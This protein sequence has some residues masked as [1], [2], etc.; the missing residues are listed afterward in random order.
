M[1]RNINWK[2]MIDPVPHPT[3][4]VPT[5]H[6]L[7]DANVVGEYKRGSTILIESFNKAIDTSR[8]S[9]L[10]EAS[11]AS[12]PIACTAISYQ[13]CFAKCLFDDWLE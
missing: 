5:W 2:S 9:S 6:G 7:V 10:A 13:I 1:N 8:S 3:L 11:P 12:H 4:P